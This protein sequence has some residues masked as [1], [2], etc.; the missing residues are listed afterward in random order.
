MVP[1]IAEPAAQAGKPQV[2]AR[3]ARVHHPAAPSEHARGTR[4]AHLRGRRSDP[5]GCALD[6]TLGPEGAGD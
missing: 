1:V 2:P 4:D 6:R 3:R 5:V